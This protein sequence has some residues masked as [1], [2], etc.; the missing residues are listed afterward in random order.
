MVQYGSVVL[1]SGGGLLLLLVVQLVLIIMMT[2][3]TNMMTRCPHY[4]F[5][6]FNSLPG[7]L[8]TQL[9]YLALMKRQRKGVAEM[10]QYPLLVSS[11]YV[12]L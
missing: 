9:P 5:L 10:L 8:K 2:M 7:H 1:F 11:L 3:T 4:Y 12:L 6:G